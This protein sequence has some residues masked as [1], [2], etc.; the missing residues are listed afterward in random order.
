MATPQLDPYDEF[1]Y[2]NYCYPQTHV[3]RLATLATLFGIKPAPVEHCR[4]L[5]LACGDGANLL[6]MAYGLPESR[7]LGIDRASK[8]ITS[9]TAL[10][11]ALRLENLELRQMD[12]M[13]VT[14]DL[15]EFDYIIAHGL[16]SW[17]PANVRDRIMEICRS[18]LAPQGIAYISYNVYPGCRLREIIR[19]MML[20]HTREAKESG[21]LVAQGRALT[22][23]LADAQLKSSVYA[24]FLRE[25]AE[26]QAKAND[27]ALYHDALAEVNE[28]LYF[29]QFMSHAKQH[30]LQFLCEAEHF[31]VR[32]Y[33]FAPE[34]IKQ[35][36]TLAEESV[37]TKEQYLDFLEGRSF[38]QS[39]LCHD[40][41][42]IDLSLGTEPIKE[43]YLS[44]PARRQSPD[45][46]LRSSEREEFQVDRDASI[47]TDFPLAKAAIYYLGEIYP[48][49]IRF[50]ELLDQ[51]FQLLNSNSSLSNR[52]SD[53]TRQL[54]DLI[55]KAYGAGVVEFHLHL[56][57]LAIVPGEHPLASPLARL[58][59]QQGTITTTLLGN[60]VR[61]ED[62]LGLQFLLLLDGTRDR[63]AL[64]KDFSE[65][66][67]EHIQPGPDGNTDERMKLLQELPERLEQKLLDLGRRGFLLA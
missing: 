30:G 37:L 11:Q 52:D 18:C 14:R 24:G 63:A 67:N 58:Q 22:K 28:P 13:R 45:Q 51:A 34:V 53:Q 59:A 12:L 47:T 6:P 32:E 42:K 33:E 43:F 54:A 41:V 21:E 25:T 44:S 60:N 36:Q 62:F 64:L 31:N 19:E 46:D 1:P 9:G 10:I 16:Y 56:P 40:E 66:I 65:V 15:G 48:R 26:N 20:F 3:D 4:V 8:P 23:W 55:L 38:R 27:G 35:L 17:V 2:D 49:A 7:F 57:R 39:L 5:E 29:H 50:D 61:I